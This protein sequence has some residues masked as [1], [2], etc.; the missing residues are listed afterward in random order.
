MEIRIRRDVFNPLLRRREVSFL[1][2]H[3]S[4][5]TPKLYDVRKSMAAKFGV[6]EDVVFIRSL[7]TLT[8]TTV[9]VGEAEVYDS[10]EAAKK[11]VPSYLL[12]RN[13]AERHKPKEGA[14]R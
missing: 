6:K 1:A 11:V 13:M 12:A 5:S 7:E 10:E 4:S 2:N 14:P 9:T 8:G 3:S